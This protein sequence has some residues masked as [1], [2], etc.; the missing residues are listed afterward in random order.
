V[1]TVALARN[2][3]SG[4]LTL[5]ETACAGPAVA[6]VAAWP[7]VVLGASQATEL[8]LVTRRLDPTATAAPRPSLLGGR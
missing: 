6:A 7:Q 2:V 4:P 1:I 5:T 8:Y 3:S